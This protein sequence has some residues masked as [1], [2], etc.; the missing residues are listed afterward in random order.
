[1]ASVTARWGHLNRQAVQKHLFILSALAPMAFIF[2]LFWIYPILRSFWGS[3]TLWRAF[4]PNAPFV[5]LRHYQGLLNDPIFLT[6]LQN[7]F[8]YALLYLPAAIVLA[9]MVALAVET[10]GILRSL[11]RMVYFIPVVTSTIATALIWAWLY[12]PT[13]G[14][15]N[16]ILQMLQLPPQSFLMSTSQALP[17]IV[18]YALWKNLGFNMVL[19]I[20]GL[21]AID[22]SLYDAAR[23]DGATQWQTFWRIT[24]PLLQPVMAFVVVTGVIGALQVFG[25]IYVMSIGGL[26][27]G[28]ANSTMVVSVYQWLIAFRELELGYGSAMGVVLF[29]I[30]LLLTLV[31][32]TFLRTR[33]EY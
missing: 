30:I 27:G 10:T 32:I 23:V 12:Q 22:T 24:L 11:F 14:L 33:W 28:P 13:F 25:P 3:V 31:Q 7:T 15:F 29:I 26:P 19:L 4:Q 16:Q 9:L 18:V 21:T 8:Y 5:G 6:A 17:S 2:A 1:M 20:A